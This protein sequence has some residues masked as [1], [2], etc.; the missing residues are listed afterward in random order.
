MDIIHKKIRDH[1]PMPKDE[2]RVEN[3]VLP[4]GFS[5]LQEISFNFIVYGSSEISSLT[6][7]K[8]M[9]KEYCTI[10]RSMIASL[11][12]FDLAHANLGEV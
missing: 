4:F 3:L 8:E 6:L 12:L 10:L 7:Q 9:I 11:D 2:S 5:L 1:V